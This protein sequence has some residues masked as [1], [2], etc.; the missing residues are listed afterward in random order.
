MELSMIL[1]SVWPI[2]KSFQKLTKILEKF[3]YF[4]P[5][6]SATFFSM[7]QYLSIQ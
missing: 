6:T 3:L 5:I 1:F 7:D 4:S 2:F